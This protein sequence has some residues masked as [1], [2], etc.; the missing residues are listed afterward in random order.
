M[1]KSMLLMRLRSIGD[2]YLDNGPFRPN[3][4]TSS[5]LNKGS[6]NTY[7]NVLYVDQPLGTGF[8]LVSTDSYDQSIPEVSAHFLTFIDKFLDTFNQFKEADIYLAGKG[9]GGVFVPYFAQEMLKRSNATSKYNVKGLIMGNPWL[10]PWHQYHAHH[11]FSVEKNLLKDDSQKKDSEDLLAKCHQEQRTTG[12]RIRSA[13]CDKILQNVLDHTLFSQDGAMHCV[14][15][16]DIRLHDV[17]PKCGITWPYEQANLSMYLRNP[18]VVK[19]LHANIKLTGWTECN[20][21]I[22]SALNTDTSEPPVKILP[23]LLEKIPLLLYSGDNDLAYN[24]LGHELLLANLT[25]GGEV[26]MGDAPVLPWF[27]NGTQVGTYQSARNITYV[28]VSQAS[29]AVG[30]DQPLPELDMVNRFMGLGDKSIAEVPSWVGTSGAPFGWEDPTGLGSGK[31]NHY[32]AATGVVALLVVGG[33][34]GLAGFLW[35]RRNRENAKARFAALRSEDDNELDELV[36]ESPA[37]F[38]ADR[39]FDVGDS[40]EEEEDYNR[41]HDDET[42][43]RKSSEH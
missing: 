10:D 4:T 36:A 30:Y 15:Q 39:H 22:A 23:E 6:W 40:E 26:G 32:Y 27:V 37:L 19:S 42:Q 12:I 9:Y 18:K 41:A 43:E 25:W 14:N 8:S 1:M 24:H 11:Q 13:T 5:Q 3:D 28:L 17:Y 34:V 31:W 38:A 35:Y 29:H 7:A 33:L 20:G 21:R 16:H 2:I